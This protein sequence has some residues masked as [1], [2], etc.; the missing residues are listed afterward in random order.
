MNADDLIKDNNEKRKLLTE[1]NLKVY[2]D[3]LLYI[4]LAHSKSEQ[5]TEELLTELL[6]HL[7]EAQAKGK[8]A[9]A[10]FGDN[11]KQYADEI[12]GEIPKMV[13]KERFDLFA[14]GLSMFFATVLVFSGIYRM[15]RYYVFQVGEAVSEVYVGTALIT[16]IASIVIAWMFVFVVF[17]YFRW[18]CFRTI[19][20]VFEFFIL[21]LGG[22]I[23]FALF[24]ALLYFTP[25]VGRM[26]EIPVYLYFVAGVVLYLAAKWSQSRAKSSI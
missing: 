6:D 25:N 7:L 4:R 15:F 16:T 2:E 11:P 5:E 9:K 26:I 23:P 10:V 8:S 3:L 13:T 22:M 12:I 18:S 19:N 14:Y 20:K 24:F 21:W 17:Q 1:E